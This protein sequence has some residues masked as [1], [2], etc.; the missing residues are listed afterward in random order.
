MVKFI[1]S[2]LI[3]LQLFNAPP[4]AAIDREY[5]TNR[6]IIIGT[7]QNYPPYSYLDNN[8]D[9]VGF[10]IEIS[11][12]VAKASGITIEIDYRPWG[13]IRNDLESGKIDAIAGMYYS[14][15]RDEFVDF[16]P[17]YAII[18]HAVFARKGAPEINSENDL[19]GK[20]IIVMQGDIMHDYV[21]QKKISQN[22]ILVTDQANAL[23]LLS[24]GHHD[25][26]L[27]A[28]LPG[29]Y[30]IKNLN[31]SNII[32][33]GKP[34]LVSK[35]CYAV[36]E[37]DSEL[38]FRLSEGLADIKKTGQYNKIY[39][40][41]LG[42]LEPKT[43]FMEIISKHTVSILLS[44][45]LIF[46]G[47][48]LWFKSLKKQ[49]A[50]RTTEL[51][52]EIKIRE[53]AEELLSEKETFLVTLIHA[54][55]IPIFYKDRD[56]RYLGCNQK[57]ESFFGKTSDQMI[58]KTVFD[59]NPPELAEIYH[60]KD[61][62]LYKIG[63]VQEY[64]TNIENA[65]DKIHDVI[66][67]KSIFADKKG[68]VKGL[69]G[70]ISDITDRKKYEK[71]LQKS[72]EKF[73]ILF[74]NSK[75][76]IYISI[77]DGTIID[78]N[79]SFFDL[80]GYTKEDLSRLKTLDLYINPKDRSMFIKKIETSG[81]AKDFEE[82][83]RDKNGREMDCQITATV[84]RSVDGAINGYQGIIRDVT[85]IKKNQIERE[86]LI[87]DLQ[88]ALK[89]VKT[90]S[91]LLPICSH[92]K[93]IRDDNGYWNQIESYIHEHSEAEFSHGICQ[94]C[95]EKYYPDMDLYGEDES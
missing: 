1:L 18:S 27:I 53:Q 44:I 10:N 93:K 62:E 30:W 76:P 39:N 38:V 88:S 32:V 56:G 12:A 35:Y 55:P 22:P 13:D 79:Q 87:A 81:F 45:F 46:F 59:I 14:K 71:K 3:V 15:A 64:E 83:L 85:E 31:L 90:L 67:Y 78:A 29:L 43:F 28:K 94:E 61:S 41:W 8:G 11:Y 54:I 26:A 7:E 57:F 77:L 34:L 47:V 21:I 80:F 82:K 70:A 58:G 49:V 16:S 6:S 95:A 92:C 33:T 4:S 23:R 51:K 25:Y 24:S 60:S 42:V 84:R 75:D 74:E 91:G 2:V 73:R 86:K 48:L 50:M 72:E 19:F 17:P 68:N 69:I 52:A 89:E 9:P 5:Q 66:F 36:K 37:G 63:G 65:H 20:K 40:H